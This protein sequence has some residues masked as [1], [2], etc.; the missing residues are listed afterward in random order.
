MIFTHREYKGAFCPLGFWHI[1]CIIM[2]FWVAR[3]LR[4]W[5]VDDRS[6]EKKCILNSNSQTSADN[7]FNLP[8][9]IVLSLTA[10]THLTQTA[11]LKPWRAKCVCDWRSIKVF[12]S[13]LSNNSNEFTTSLSTKASQDGENLKSFVDLSDTNGVISSLA[14]N[15]ERTWLF[16]ASD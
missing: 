9:L 15:R 3:C 4:L 6:R 1:C 2:S 8:A 11:D 5:R 16:V 7:S 12:L 10:N 13:R 14:A